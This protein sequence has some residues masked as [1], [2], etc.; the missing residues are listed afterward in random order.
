MSLTPAG[1]TNF[2]LDQA[3]LEA[4]AG[5]GSEALHASRKSNSLFS[6]PQRPSRE[7]SATGLV[8]VHVPSGS[9]SIADSSARKRQRFAFDELPRSDDSG[10]KAPALRHH[11]GQSEEALVTEGWPDN[12]DCGQSPDTESLEAS[13]PL[14]TGILSSPTPTVP[15]TAVPFW[16]NLSEDHVRQVKECLG[17]GQW[18]NDDIVLAH[19]QILAAC[20][21]D[22]RAVDGMELE[23]LADEPQGSVRKKAARIISRAA[24][25]DKLSFITIFQPMIN[26]WALIHIHVPT[27]TV[28]L[29]DSL[30]QTPGNPA[31]IQSQ[32]YAKS[33]VTKVL[34]E[35]QNCWAD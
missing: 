19:V 26:H 29:V 7:G 15:H 24:E 5:R 35:P 1:P 22:L 33:F 28:T 14:A 34:P 10:R 6:S 16:S 32:E 31:W 12:Q 11:L 8:E 4:E 18:L 25:A 3:E 20:T 17:P 30:Y 2:I 21:P 9:P 27:K 23:R 13:V